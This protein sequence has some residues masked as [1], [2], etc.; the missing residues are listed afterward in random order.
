[1]HGQ[2]LDVSVR[3]GAIEDASRSEDFGI[4]LR[5]FKGLRHA[6]GSTADAS[7][8]GLIKLAEQVCAMADVVPTDAY[9]RLARVGEFAQ[10]YPDLDL[11]DQDMAFSVKDLAAFAI[12]AEAEALQQKGITKSDSASAGQNLHGVG[13]STS[14]GFS[15][16][17]WYS[18]NHISLGVIGG[19]GDSMETDHASSSATHLT[20][21]ES[22]EVVGRRA[23][24]R[25]LARLNPR[26]GKTGGFPVIFDRRV[27]SSLLRTLSR[28]ISGP[29]IAK[30]TSFLCGKIG[31]VIFSPDIRIIDDP[32]KIRGHRSGP[33]D[34]EGLPVFRRVMVDG[35]QLQ[36]YFLD[37]RSAARLGMQPTGHATRGLSAPPSPA[38]SNLWIEPGA[39]SRAQMIKNIGEGFLVTDLMGASISLETGD[40]SRGASGFWI[41]AGEIAYPVSEMTIAGN[42]AEMFL[43]LSPASDLEFRDGVD[44]PS[45]LIEG[46]TTASR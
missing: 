1:M 20:D 40:Y 43:H 17:Y 26:T 45:L 9:T 44:A 46:M 36:S 30:G 34:G 6:Y 16:A 3:D 19:R 10:N 32:L 42:L 27:S 2:S 41:E 37:I 12:R 4:G 21:I 39:Y 38:P 25:T 33:F 31:Q 15:G 23:A 28:A 18:S 8:E 5:V 24:E 7:N 11:A 29:R 35:G 13:Y 14:S 22:P